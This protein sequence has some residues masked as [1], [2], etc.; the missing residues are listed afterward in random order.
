MQS[1]KYILSRAIRKILNPPAIDHSTISKSARCD[2]GT[3][4]S[5]SSMGDYSYI[6]EFT[7]LLYTDVGKFC[8]I[9]NYCAI[10]GASHPLKWV[11]MSPAFNDSKGMMKSKI[12]HFHYEP[13]IRTNIGN[14]VWIGS[15]CL[16]K[17]G[18]TIADGAVIGM[19]S[20]VTH[21]VGPYEIW[22]GN[23]AICIKKR[24]PDDDIKRLIS[25]AWWEWDEGKI[26][27]CANTFNNVNK[28]LEYVEG[29]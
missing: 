26:A 14:D 22:A 13:F 3:V 21:D 16:I 28:M 8:S 27:D 17:A 18:I 5:S 10:G 19:G 29:K 25:V 7:H 1:A 15:H 4:V 12:A 23:P 11:S 2:I 6:G 20:V 24:F 9:S